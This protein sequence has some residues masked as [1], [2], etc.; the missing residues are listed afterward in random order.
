MAVSNNISFQDPHGQRGNF[1]KK[2]KENG[3]YWHKHGMR[4]SILVCFFPTKTMGIIKIKF[5]HYV[6]KYGSWYWI[7]RI[8][9]LLCRY[10]SCWSS[11][12]CLFNIQF[13]SWTW[14]LTHLPL[15]LL[16]L[17]AGPAGLVSAALIEA[18]VELGGAHCG[19][20]YNDNILFFCIY[21]TN[22]F[23]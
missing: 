7:T 19:I 16:R 2:R 18:I 14:I 6:E 11:A 10:R 3:D 5:G 4:P 8:F 17:P 13:N 21:T 20:E 12:L 23:K 15:A 1:S 9:F 22:R